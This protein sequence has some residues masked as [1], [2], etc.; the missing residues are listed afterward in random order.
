MKQYPEEQI[1][2]DKILQNVTIPELSST[3]LDH[4]TNE[5]KTLQKKQKKR[6]FVHI[7][8]EA[9]PFFIIFLQWA[10]LLNFTPIIS[11]KIIL[12]LTLGIFHGYI[13]YQWVIY[14][15]HEGAG[16]GLFK[17]IKNPIGQLFQFLA[18]NSSRIMMADPINYKK[19]HLLHHAFLGT[20]R[21]GSQV[22][23]VQR[24]RILKSILP[25]AGIIIKNDYCVHVGES[26]DFST[27]ISFI[28]GGL[29][30]SV[31]YY[32]LKDFLSFP[33]TVLCLLILSPWVGLTLDRIRESVEHFG[34]PK[35]NRYGSKDL[36]LTIESMII[37]GGPWGQPYHLAHHLYPQLNWYQ[38]IKLG[39]KLEQIFSK[40]Q[41]DF[42]KINS[43]VK[44]F[45]QQLNFQL[46]IENKN[47]V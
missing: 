30:F 25:G 23:Y 17:E 7:F 14:S 1:F 36:G 24:K 39:K 12:I 46:N 27:A 44:T 2:L 42:F 35:D 41:K 9:A 47:S 11:N 10:L 18:F 4:L 45:I 32:L 37:A 33:E 19:N 16:H 43:V 26:I 38:Q 40:K 13:G 6:R 3:Q 8:L 15:L 22:N 28:I 21:D 20:D 5:Y 34:M 31:E 29:R